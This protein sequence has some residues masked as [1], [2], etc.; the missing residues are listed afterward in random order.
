MLARTARSITLLMLKR[1][2]S[3]DGRTIAY[4]DRGAGPA[5]LL[6]HGYALDSVW[7]FDAF[8]YSQPMFQRA[9]AMYEREMGIVAPV[10]DPPEE[11]H[12]GLLA[13]LHAAGARTIAVDARGFGASD[14]PR[15]ASEY[16]DD[17]TVLD[18]EALI[19]HLQLEEVDVVGYSMGA[20]TA[21]RLLTRRYPSVKSALLAGIGDYVLEG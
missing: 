17:A 1:F 19:A 6:L 16:A 5:V 9:A 12:G 20:Q 7:N 11:T 2:H 10:P 14:K 4:Y 8:D 3:F 13:R 15:H 18:V 21:A